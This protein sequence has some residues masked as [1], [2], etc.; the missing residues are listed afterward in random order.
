MHPGSNVQFQDQKIQ[1]TQAKLHAL[2]RE[3]AGPSSKSLLLQTVALFEALLAR[4]K[5]LQ[6]ELAQL[7][8]KEEEEEEKEILEDKRNDEL[9]LEVESLS[10]ELA[11][12]KEDLEKIQKTL[13]EERQGKHNLEIQLK[14]R[15]K[16]LRR[17]KKSTG[18]SR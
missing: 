6:T 17:K 16:M 4:I 10:R 9:I 13:E 2:V 5:E 11:S 8:R 14:G 12:T 18:D 15:T 1:E 3:V 7:K